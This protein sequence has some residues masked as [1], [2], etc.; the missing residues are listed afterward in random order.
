MAFKLL[1][2]CRVMRT[3]RKLLLDPGSVFHLIWRGHN[4]E[5]IFRDP[6]D[7][8]S[9]LAC[10]MSAVEAE[11]DPDFSIESFCV[12]SNHLHATVRLGE[13]VEVLSR[14]LRRAHMT[15][16]MRYN[17]R[18]S[19]SGAVGND[20]PKTIR[21]QDDRAQIRTVFYCDANP[22]RAG[23]VKDPRSY[24]WST[25]NY[26]AFGRPNRFVASSE[27]DWYRRLGN[28]QS[29]RRRRYRRLFALYLR[30]ERLVRLPR[31]T[32]GNFCGDAE[33]VSSESRALRKAIFGLARNA[34][35]P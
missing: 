6:E 15:F 21:L 13:D 30:T 34:R 32:S 17:R 11:G 31:W 24:F 12:M 22:I 28:N 18:R 5:W 33:W 19:R 16:A 20:R 10:L 4:R 2:R 29:Q 25:Y 9:Y 27:P 1:L 8:N 3:P 35:A 26:F 7:K 23:L 14:V